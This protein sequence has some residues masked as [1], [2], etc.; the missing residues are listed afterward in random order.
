M[1]TDRT[2]KLSNLALVAACL[3]VFI[4]LPIDNVNLP[5]LKGLLSCGISQAMVPIFFFISG[6]FA[7]VGLEKYG[8]KTLLRKKI[9]T[10][11]IPY[12]LLNSLVFGFACIEL[13]CGQRYGFTPRIT[14]IS[15]HSFLI[16]QGFAKTRWAIL[17]PL[18]YVRCLASFFVLAPLLGYFIFRSRRSAYVVFGTLMGLEVAYFSLSLNREILHLVSYWFSLHGLYCFA[19]GMIFSCHFGFLTSSLLSSSNYRWLSARRFVF[20]GGSGIVLALL[21]FYFLPCLVTRV[22][23]DY[24]SHYILL[25][26]VGVSLYLVVPRTRFP[27]FLLRNTFGIYVLHAIVIHYLSLIGFRINSPMSYFGFWF[28][29]VAISLLI[30]ELMHRCLPKSTSILFGGR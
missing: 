21:G 26:L 4:H 27:V 16:A 14:N 3:V 10:L 19:A 5:I 30:S 28:A 15:M 25:P 23:Q 13:L 6:L 24:V 22:V 2:N 8:W 20:L 1:R 12:L 17:Y 9:F 7:A 18:W 29:T 11:V